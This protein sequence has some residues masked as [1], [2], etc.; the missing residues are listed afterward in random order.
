MS[1]GDSDVV[2]QEDVLRSRALVAAAQTVNVAGAGDMVA[3]D[4]NDRFADAIGRFLA[5]IQGQCNA[6]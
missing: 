5:Q 6:D 2:R 4:R 1:G 3:G